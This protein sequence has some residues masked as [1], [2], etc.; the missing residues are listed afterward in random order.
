VHKRKQLC[1]DKLAPQS[2]TIQLDT[3][4]TYL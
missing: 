3:N 1:V 4:T 2:P